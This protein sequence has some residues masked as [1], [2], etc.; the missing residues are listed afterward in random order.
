MRIVG[1]A[2]GQHLH[3]LVQPMGAV[4]AL[5]LGLEVLVDV[6]QMGDVGQ[7]V[8]ELLVGQAGGGAS[9]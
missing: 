4:F 8:V 9:R 2:R 6:D 7:R 3:F 5:E 1:L